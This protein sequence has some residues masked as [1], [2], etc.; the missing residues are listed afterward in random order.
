MSKRFLFISLI[1]AMKLVLPVKQN[2]SLVGSRTFFEESKLVANAA[3]SS[4]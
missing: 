1:F 4:Y 3:L 2:K